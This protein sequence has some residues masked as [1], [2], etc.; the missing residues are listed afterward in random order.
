MD[1]AATSMSL[2]SLK[3]GLEVGA[4]VTK[5]AMESAEVNMEGITEML[6]AV[7]QMIPSDSI[8]DVRA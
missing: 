3:L 2:A 6:E 7:D 5:K 1:V 8:I 4:S